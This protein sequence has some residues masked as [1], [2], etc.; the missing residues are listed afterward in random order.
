MRQ[1]HL[2]KR[3]KKMNNEKI[4]Y[5]IGS[6]N[7]FKDLEI[8]NP[9]EYLAKTRLALII[10]N[11]ITEKK[12]K[13]NKAAAHLGISKQE[14]TAL[15]NGRLDDFPMEHLFAMLRKL[16]RDIEIVVRERPA[17][18]PPA[19]INIMAQGLEENYEQAD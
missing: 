13:H 6:G 16:D 15:L 1:K 4:E 9:E 3:R 8:P 2:L 5:E 19:E 7:V 11:I 12:L 17:D 10:Y 14:V 18:T